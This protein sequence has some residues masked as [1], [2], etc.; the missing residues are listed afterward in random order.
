MYFKY[1]YLFFMRIGG[2]ENWMH[3][4]AVKLFSVSVNQ[5]DTVWL[6]L[7]GVWREGSV[8]TLA[9]VCVAVNCRWTFAS[10]TL[11]AAV[12]VT[13]FN[14]P[15][16]PPPHPPAWLCGRAME[17]ED[18]E[19]MAI[20]SS[21]VGLFNVKSVHADMFRSLWWRGLFSF[22]PCCLADLFF[23]FFFGVILTFSRGEGWGSYVA[24]VWC[25]RNLLIL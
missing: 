19:V 18:F 13:S 1:H 5:L 25:Y 6:D 12:A 10:T 4:A 16:P 21:V 8:L 20:L 24:V 11:P 15:P 14:P 2:N 9:F 23:F 22:C 3:S 17:W 7:F